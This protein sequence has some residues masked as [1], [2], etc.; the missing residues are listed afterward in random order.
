MLCTTTVLGHGRL[1]L[2][3]DSR[4][5]QPLQEPGIYP[6]VQANS[7]VNSKDGPGT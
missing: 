6:L 1:L 7:S 5:A 2:L 4:G 3:P